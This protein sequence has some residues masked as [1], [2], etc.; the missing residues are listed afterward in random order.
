VVAA[1]PFLAT[2]IAVVVALSLL[3]PYTFLDRIWTLNPAAYAAFH[4]LGKSSGVILLVLGVCTGTTAFGLLRQRRW[5]WWLAIVL[6]AA[7]GLGDLTNLLIGGERW[8]SAAG[9]L[10]AA[11]FVFLLMRFPRH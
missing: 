11:A 6:F 1:F 4:I 9:A 3:F 5:A 2:L 10:I 7:N 8:K